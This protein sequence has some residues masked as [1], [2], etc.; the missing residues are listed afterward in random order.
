[1]KAAARVLP[2]PPAKAG[3]SPAFF[4]ARGGVDSQVDDLPPRIA[5]SVFGPYAPIG[6]L[7]YGALASRQPT[8]PQGDR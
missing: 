5:L 8:H 6:A 2:K 7:P 3:R 4:V 1:M